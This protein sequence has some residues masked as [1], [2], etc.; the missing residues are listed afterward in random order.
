MEVVS[1]KIVI[2]DK[3]III[4]EEQL[5]LIVKTEVSNLLTREFEYVISKITDTIT[6]KLKEKQLLTD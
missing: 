4:S 1:K 5:R 2:M 6:E 3:K